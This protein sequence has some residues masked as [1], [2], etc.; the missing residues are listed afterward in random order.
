MVH[1]PFYLR[2]PRVARL[3]QM[4]MQSYGSQ[5]LGGRQVFRK[6]IPPCRLLFRGFGKFRGGQRFVRPADRPEQF[7]PVV[8]ENLCLFLP[9]C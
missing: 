3:G 9:A 4:V 8:R 6:P 7:L 5:L 2:V 1:A